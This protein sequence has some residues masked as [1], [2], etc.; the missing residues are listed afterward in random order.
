MPVSHLIPTRKSGYSLP[1]QTHSNNHAIIGVKF[2]FDG[3]Q[4]PEGIGQWR[5]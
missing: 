5:Q 3:K 1:A 4:R 2:R